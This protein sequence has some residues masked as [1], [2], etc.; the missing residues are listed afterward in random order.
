MWVELT[1]GTVPAYQ[2]HPVAVLLSAFHE[3]RKADVTIAAA[4]DF[5]RSEVMSLVLAAVL[6]EFIDQGYNVAADIAIAGRG[7][8]AE[9]L[10]PPASGVPDPAGE[11]LDITPRTGAT[12]PQKGGLTCP[13]YAKVMHAE[14]GFFHIGST[15]GNTV[16]LS[17]AGV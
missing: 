9:I 12:S 7:F 10:W 14:R 6:R 3:D 11:T 8:T 16:L 2:G 1:L 5:P 13:Q 15:C 17:L 4:H